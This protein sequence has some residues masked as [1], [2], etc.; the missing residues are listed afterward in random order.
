VVVYP[1]RLHSSDAPMSTARVKGALDKDVIRRIVV[2]HINEVRHC[3][4]QGLVR[5]PDLEGRVAVQFTIGPTGRVPVA[6]VK[7]SSLGDPHVGTC[8]AKAVK[9]WSFPE[10]AG[11]GNVVVTYPFQLAP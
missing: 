7:E 10:P 9:R 5:D 4:D 6:V 2:A 1:I 3:S 11:G 8:I